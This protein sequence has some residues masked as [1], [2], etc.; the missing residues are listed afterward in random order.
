MACLAAPLFMA[1]AARASPTTAASAPASLSLQRG[2]QLYARCAGCHAVEGHRTGP[3]H[4]GLFGRRAGHAS[5]FE[6]YSDAMRASKLVWNTRTLDAFLKDPMQA[7]PGTSMG[8]A[9]VKDDRERADLIAWL[10]QATR[11]GQACT[12]SQASPTESPTSKTGARR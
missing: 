8:Y 5:G 7:L 12:A 4:C 9:G 11:A 6:G 2:E 10:R 1:G 3:E